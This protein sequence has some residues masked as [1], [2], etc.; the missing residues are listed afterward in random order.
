MALYEFTYIFTHADGCLWGLNAAARREYGYF[1]DTDQLPLTAQTKAEIKRL[2]REYDTRFNWEIMEELWSWRDKH[3]FKKR[4]NSLLKVIRKELGENYSIRT[5]RKSRVAALRTAFEEIGVH[6]A[7]IMNYCFEIASAVAPY[8]GR[9]YTATNYDDFVYNGEHFRAVIGKNGDVIGFWPLDKYRPNFY[10]EKLKEV[11]LSA[12]P[13]VL[14]APEIKMED[15]KDPE[16]QA[17]REA[18]FARL[19]LEHHYGT[20]DVSKWV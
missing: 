2:Y 18:T 15:S 7:D 16:I 17:R 9:R 8:F 10:P 12:E 3:Q 13:Y 19:S 6:G 4:T 5:D 11:A 1:V 20:S 14:T